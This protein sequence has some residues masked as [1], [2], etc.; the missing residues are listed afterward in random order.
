MVPR[1]GV[2]ASYF[3]RGQLEY[4]QYLRVLLEVFRMFV[5]RLLLVLGVLYCSYSQYSQFSGLHYCSCCRH[6]Q[7]FGRQF[8]NTP[9]TRSTKCTRFSNVKSAYEVC[10]EHLASVPYSQVGFPYRV[11]NFRYSFVNYFDEFA[12][13]VL[14]QVRVLYE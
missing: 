8:C 14:S 7:Y 6:S 10:W 3:R 12:K 1:V 13:M 2:G 9:S 5:L 4:L 11:K